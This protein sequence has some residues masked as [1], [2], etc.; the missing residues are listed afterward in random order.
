MQQWITWWNR[1]VAGIDGCRARRTHAKRA[2]STIA[3]LAALA[4]GAT[5]AAAGDAVALVLEASGDIVPAVTAYQ[6]I[7]ADTVLQLGQNAKIRIAHLALCSV[8][9]A[10]GDGRFVL[11]QKQFAW[12]GH[13]PETSQ[14]GTCIHRVTYIDPDRDP[15]GIQLRAPTPPV[16]AP[17][18]VFILE[19]F[20]GSAT[21]Q[22]SIK[23]LGDAGENIV[24]A[25]PS[26]I[27]AWPD[28]AKPLERGRA[29]RL[30]LIR[31][32][33][34]SADSSSFIVAASDDSNLDDAPLLIR[35][36]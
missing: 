8:I 24:V 10:E 1:Q 21:Y 36:R 22:I 28:D 12:T 13:T 30:T 2:S 32:G 35:F 29:Y 33:K 34:P 11:A 15:A 31:E 23:S 16:L 7:E 25:L 3:L 18:P 17:R 6:T 14:S 27:A 19:N 26:A 20:D 4:F 9:S 5:P